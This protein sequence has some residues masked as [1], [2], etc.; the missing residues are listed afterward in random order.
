LVKRNG[1]E[2]AGILHN[3]FMLMLSSLRYLKDG[4]RE[5]LGLLPLCVD[6]ISIIKKENKNKTLKGPSKTSYTI[7]QCHEAFIQFFVPNT[8]TE[9]FPSLFS[10]SPR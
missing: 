10:T 2:K 8:G 5:H 9:F 7:G 6:K 4:I 3:K 1:E